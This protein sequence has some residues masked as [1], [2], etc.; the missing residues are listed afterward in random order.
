MRNEIF[1]YDRDCSD[2][3]E[4]MHFQNNSFVCNN[5]NCFN[6]DNAESAAISEEFGEITIK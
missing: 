2:C 1:I 5:I 6:Y 4:I 3:G